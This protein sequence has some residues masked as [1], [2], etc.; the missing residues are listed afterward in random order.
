[1]HCSS[2][3]FRFQPYALDAL[4]AI[5]ASKVLDVYIGIYVDPLSP[6]DASAAAFDVISYLH[7]FIDEETLIDHEP[8]DWRPNL[9][10]DMAMQCALLENDESEGGRT[11]RFPRR[12]STAGD[13]EEENI[14]TTVSF[15][16]S[17]LSDFDD[18]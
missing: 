13:A 18:Y 2:P 11:D 17:S 14:E 3:E 16:L 12:A 4:Q 1:M 10:R 9:A 7:N 6:P 5:A 15:E 8:P